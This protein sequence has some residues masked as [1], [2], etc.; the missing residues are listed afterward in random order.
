MACPTSCDHFGNSQI[1]SVH[2]RIATL[3]QK[4]IDTKKEQT[5]LD[6]DVR[7]VVPV[8][9]YRVIAVILSCS[10]LELHIII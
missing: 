6:H 2:V 8:S 10:N 4:K 9:E 5:R 1:S 7:L 3:V